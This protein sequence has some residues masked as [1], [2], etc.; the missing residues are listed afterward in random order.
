MSLSTAFDTARSSLQT[1]SSRLSVSARN[2]ASADDASASRKIA[3]VTTNSDGTT[4]VVSITRASDSALFDR[5]LTATSSS[6]ALTAVND[7]LTVLQQTVGDTESETSPAA[8]LGAFSDAMSTAANSP[9]DAALAQAAVNAAQDLARSLND[10]STAVQQVRTDA[11]S[12]IATSVS[13]V[14]DLLA[15]FKEANDAVV[16]GT[17]NGRDVTDAMDKRDT[18]LAALSEE[19]GVSTLTRANNDVAIYTDS[20]VT[21]FDKSARSV[22]FEASGVFDAATSGHAVYVDGVAVA[23][24][25][26]SSSMALKTGTIAGLAELRDGATVTYQAQLDEVARGLISAFEESDQSGSGGATLEGL[27][28]SGGGDASLAGIAGTISVNA[29]ADSTQGGSALTLRDGGLNG[30]DYVYNTDSQA[31]YSGRLTELVNA[32]GETRTYDSSTQLQSGTSLLKFATSSVSWLEGQR[33]TASTRLDTQSAIL[34]QTSTALS[35]ATGVNLDEEYAL[36]LQLERSYQASSKLIG[37]V[38]SLYDTLFA[39]IG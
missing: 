10:A 24:P 18:I 20:G 3:V 16:E 32:L 14:N 17:A 29:A 11:D 23:G 13:N 19:M 25:G 37:V 4:K 15:Q 21:L 7:G 27:F 6:A 33:S 38:D 35:S 12:S 2:V 22:T 28:T 34:T 5:M 31:S 39:A 9:D 36:Q 26:A 1:T 30:S 8:L